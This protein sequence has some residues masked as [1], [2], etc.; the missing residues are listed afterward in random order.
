MPK[1]GAGREQV[2]LGVSKHLFSRL[3][4][5]RL[6]SSGGLAGVLLDLPVGEPPGLSHDHHSSSARGERSTENTQ[7]PP[8]ALGVGAQS[9]VGPALKERFPTRLIP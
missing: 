6:G 5:E 8:T 1:S 4:A 7:A 9:Q 2:G 3:G